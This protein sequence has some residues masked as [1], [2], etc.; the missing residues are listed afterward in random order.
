MT[1]KEGGDSRAVRTHLQATMFCKTWN[2]ACRMY[3]DKDI[4]MPGEDGT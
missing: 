3:I 1:Q 4:L 2:C